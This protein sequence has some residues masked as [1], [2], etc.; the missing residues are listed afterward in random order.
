MHCRASLSSASDRQLCDE[1]ING[2]RL[3]D[4][5]CCIAFSSPASTQR[6]SAAEAALP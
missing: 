4:K 1:A 6:F 2:E 5:A 3:P